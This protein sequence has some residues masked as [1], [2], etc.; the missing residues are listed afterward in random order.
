M[1][2]D[3]SLQYQAVF[4]RGIDTPMPHPAP[5]QVKIFGML[6]NKQCLSLTVPSL[7]FQVGPDG[8]T[9]IMPDKTSGAESDFVTAPPQ[10]P[11]KIDIIAGLATN[12]IESINLRRRLGVTAQV[13]A[14]NV[15]GF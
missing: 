2:N 6:T 8:G 13:A 15:S 10:A 14:G 12:G 9:P 5:D 3:T 4:G 1:I 7:L 11:A